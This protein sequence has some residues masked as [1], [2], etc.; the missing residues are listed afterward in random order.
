LYLEQKI[1][2]N[3]LKQ[4]IMAIYGDN[5]HNFKSEGSFKQ[6]EGYFIEW[7]GEHFQS[8]FP[9][10]EAANSQIHS[11]IEDALLYMKEEL[12]VKE[13]ITIL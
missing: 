13:I 4:N 3:N 1:I 12:G 11:S 7:N 10:C 5:K 6:K 8:V 2:N 9:E